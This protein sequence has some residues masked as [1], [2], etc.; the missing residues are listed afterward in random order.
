MPWEVTEVVN[1]RMRFVVRRE[2][3]VPKPDL[4]L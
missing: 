2:S 3:G 4:G 1:E